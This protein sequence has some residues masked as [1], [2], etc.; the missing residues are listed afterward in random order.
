MTTKRDRAYYERRL[1]TEH[2]AT[3]QELQRGDYGSL[4]DA[5]VAC[6][7]RKPRTRLH[8]LRNAWRKA[9]ATEQSTFLRDLG[10]TISLPTGAAPPTVPAAPAMFVNRRLTPAGKAALRRFMDGKGLGIRKGQI[11]KLVNRSPYDQ[12]LSSAMAQGNPINERTKVA[13][14]TGMV[15]VLTL[16]A[17]LGAASGGV[18]VPAGQHPLC[19][20]HGF[21]RS[22]PSRS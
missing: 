7:L 4:N 15:L 13:C 5:L 17:P 3:Y 14:P 20:Q 12:S 21:R 2:P 16:S 1:K 10:V 22:I 11:M 19:V 6:G 18:Q 9:S 8:E